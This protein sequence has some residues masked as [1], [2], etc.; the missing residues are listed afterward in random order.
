[1][2]K[3]NLSDLVILHRDVITGWTGK[4]PEQLK[5]RNLW[6]A[7]AFGSIT[8]KFM[9]IVL[10]L[11]IAEFIRHMVSGYD[12]SFVDFVIGFYTVVTLLVWSINVL[13]VRK[14]I[15]AYDKIR[16]EPDDGS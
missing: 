1:M 10:I 13:A 5:G 14:H 15:A 4:E 2:N 7:V 6:Y 16:T 8:M 11:M 9:L 3:K 12:L